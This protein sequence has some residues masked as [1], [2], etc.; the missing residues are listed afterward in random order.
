[1]S[2]EIDV[3]RKVSK[4]QKNQSERQ[5]VDTKKANHGRIALCLRKYP[6]W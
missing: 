4:S 6:T 5:T 2:I 3:S 1:M